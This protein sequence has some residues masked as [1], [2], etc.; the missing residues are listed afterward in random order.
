MDT[1]N[2]DIIWKLFKNYMI[3]YNLNI[4]NKLYYSP[5]P[6]HLSKNLKKLERAGKKMVK[7]NS[8]NSK[9]SINTFNKSW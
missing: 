5:W 7:C 2:L 6:P 9:K 8:K 1:T 3:W 4:K